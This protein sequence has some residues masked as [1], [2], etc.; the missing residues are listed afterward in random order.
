MTE[1]GFDNLIRARFTMEHEDLELPPKLD[2]ALQQA[3]TGPD[4]QIEQQCSQI[5]RLVDLYRSLFNGNYENQ[6]V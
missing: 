6:H 5:C 4:A 3:L 2:Q 1:F